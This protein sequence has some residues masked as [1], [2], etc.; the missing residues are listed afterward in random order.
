LY[1]AERVSGPNTL[2]VSKFD[3]S[4]TVKITIHF[5]KAE[6][7]QLPGVHMTPHLPV[8]WGCG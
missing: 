3:V 1:Y 4:L 6:L 7:T 2:I 8:V 5:Y